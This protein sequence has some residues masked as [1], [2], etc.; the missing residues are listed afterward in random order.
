MLRVRNCLRAVQVL[1]TL[2]LIHY[3]FN[4]WS[5]TL[6][7]LFY[8]S[9]PIPVTLLPPVPSTHVHE[10]MH[11]CAQTPH[12]KEQGERSSH[13]RKA[14][15]GWPFFCVCCGSYNSLC[16]I[17]SSSS[18]PFN[19]SLVTPLSPSLIPLLSQLLSLCLR[20]L[21][22]HFCCYSTSHA[23]PISPLDPT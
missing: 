23:L 17:I 7:T 13:T 2:K 20:T 6:P 1:L 8:L 9:L 14:M 16:L 3:R 11:V 4:T 12:K 18:K 5:F 19:A 22:L 10:H 21:C 15:H